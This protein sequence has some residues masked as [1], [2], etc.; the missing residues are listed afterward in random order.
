MKNKKQS[1]RARIL[2]ENCGKEEKFVGTLNSFSNFSPSGKEEDKILKVLVVPLY[3]YTEEGEKKYLGHA[4]MEATPEMIEHQGETA[5]F[6]GKSYRYSKQSKKESFGV[7]FT[8]DV[9]Y[10]G[11]IE[12]FDGLK[13]RQA[14]SHSQDRSKR[15]SKN[16]NIEVIR[17]FEMGVL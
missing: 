7:K 6:D 16:T 12:E 11:V 10:K 15:R 1:F 9:E 2:S 3:M 17:A 5:V 14:Q 4:W 8:G 13:M